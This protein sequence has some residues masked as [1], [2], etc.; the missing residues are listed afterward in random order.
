V[1][2]LKEGRDQPDHYVTSVQSYLMLSGGIALLLGLV[3]RPAGQVVGWITWVFLTYTIEMVRL[4]AR[5]PCASVE[6]KMEGW[7]VWGYYG[8]L[9]G[10]T[11]WFKQDK[12]RRQEIWNR[13]IV[14][15]RTRLQTQV[16]LGVTVVLLVLAFAFWQGLPDGKLH[17]VFLDVGQGDA[18]FIETP[19]GK[20]VLIDGG[21]SE[22]QV[23][24]QLG[25]QMPFW[26]RSLDLVVLTHPDAD[27]VNGLV[28][29]L[30]QYRVAAVLHRQIELDS[31]TYAYW[32]ALVEAEGAVVYEGQA[33][34][35]LTLDEGLEM[36][37]LHPGTQTWE[38]ANDNSVV[39]RLTYGDVSLLLTGD[40]EA[41]VEE[42]LVRDAAPL[43][44]TILKAAHHGSCSS[45]TQVFLDAVDPELVVISVGV[46]NR[47]GHPCDE[48]LERLDDLPFYRTDEHG[49]VEVVS[50]GMWVW[51]EVER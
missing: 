13:V 17:V 50:D 8:L 7:M 44:S 9:A 11:W 5:V 27:H 15:L 3:F 25:N 49:P 37:V 4:T 41:E 24:A 36:T 6:V 40:I 18:I 21:P 33:G 43:A 46:D 20:Q 38:G 31:E 22:T 42:G 39:T 34:L 28:P 48:V 47:F 12:E 51:V 30:E 2:Q 35:R 32:L 26:D 14:A 10:L 16:I 45:T 23:L 1:F 19:S 29:V